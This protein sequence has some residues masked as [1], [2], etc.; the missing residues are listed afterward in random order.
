MSYIEKIVLRTHYLFHLFIYLFISQTQIY[1]IIN[2]SYKCKQ[3]CVCRWPIEN[4]NMSCHQAP[5]N[6]DIM[7]VKN[8]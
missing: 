4:Q 2:T 6:I 3:K 1:T 7:S 8:F 5:L